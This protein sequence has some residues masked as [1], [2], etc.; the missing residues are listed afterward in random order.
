MMLPMG[1]RFLRDTSR[2]D[3]RRCGV[4]AL[5]GV[6]LAL[7]AGTLAACVDDA[8]PQ[9]AALQIVR[10]VAADCYS[11][12]PAPLYPV[13]S[14]QKKEQGTV[15]IAVLLDSAGRQKQITIQTSSGYPGLD[16]SALTAVRAARFNPYAPDGKAQP[17]W[18][19]VPIKFALSYLTLDSYH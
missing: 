13:L 1:E 10:C 11:V 5:L 19:M 9:T 7:S 12:P 15:L 2:L 16:Q 4:K 14:R 3:F 18:V 17:V 8:P 6:L